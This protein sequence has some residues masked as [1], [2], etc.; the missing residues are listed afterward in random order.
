M[1]RTRRARAGR[2]GMGL[3]G[4]RAAFRRDG[5]HSAAAAGVLPSGVCGACA[6][7]LHRSVCGIAAGVG[8]GTAGAA[9]VLPG[10]DRRGFRPANKPGI[11][12]L[13]DRL[14]TAGDRTPRR[15]DT[16]KPGSLANEAEPRRNRPPARE[17]PFGAA[18]CG[19]IGQRRDPAGKD[20]AGRG[21]G[22][23]PC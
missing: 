20:E 9:G 7:V 17:I 11:K 23:F 3:V 8:A 2:T 1:V 22:P 14:R 10:G 19:R 6:T 5:V 16:G 15:P 4:R 18:R 21:A 13:P 12:K